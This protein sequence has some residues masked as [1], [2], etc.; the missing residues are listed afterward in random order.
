MTI[1]L[2]WKMLKDDSC[3]CWFYVGSV[4]GAALSVASCGGVV[5]GFVEG[6]GKIRET[7]KVELLYRTS[8]VIKPR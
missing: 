2:M 8:S 4:C 5:E 6:V 1:Y 7:V 3:V